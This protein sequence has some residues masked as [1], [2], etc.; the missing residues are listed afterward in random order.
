MG[1]VTYS[2]DQIR[3]FVMS[4]ILK[5]FQQGQNNGDQPQDQKDCLGC[6]MMASGVMT[7][8]GAYLFS[9]LVFANNGKPLPNVTPGYA[10]AVRTAGV[11]VFLFGIYRGWE[12]IKLYQEKGWGGFE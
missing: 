9:G 4:N 6:L 5:I 7:L 2:S 12:A 3:S 1:T 8:G 10:L 11:P